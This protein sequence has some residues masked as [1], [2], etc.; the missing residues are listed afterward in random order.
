MFFVCT[1]IG[2]NKLGGSLRAA[3]VRGLVEGGSVRAVSR[4]TGV[5][6]TTILRL[7]AEVGD[8][9]AFYQHV[10]F[11]NLPCK[12]VE[13]DEIWAFVGA[14]EKRAKP[15]QGDLWTYTAIDAES[16]L[17]FSWLIGPRSKFATRAFIR[18]M[19]SRIAGRFQL[20]TDGLHWYQQSVQHALAGRCDYAQVIKTFGSTSD[21]RNPARRYS[22]AECTAI[23]KV[24]VMGNPDMDLASTSYVERNNLSI[25]TSNRRFT[26]LTNGFSKK[27][28]NHIH[29]FAIH[30]MHF[31][32]CRAH[33]TLTKNSGRPTTP[34]M[35]AGLTRKPWTVEQMLERMDAIFVL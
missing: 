22:P 8:F 17:L 9:C 24:W 14:K 10:A 2:M 33:G 25:R 18:D 19:A 15:G 34:A 4:I 32:F 3:V 23:Q 29:A 31:N 35:S 28:E 1:F 20:T 7:L 30:A 12:R 6:V 21:E 16:R 5:A 11:R 13:A 26:R 27:A